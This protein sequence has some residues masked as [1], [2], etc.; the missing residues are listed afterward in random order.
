MSDLADA[1]RQAGGMLAGREP[2][3]WRIAGLSLALSVSATAGASIAA[4]PFASALAGSRF[5]GRRVVDA[6]LAAGMAFPTVLIGLILFSLFARQGPLGT[7]QLLYTP[8][9]MG[10]GQFLL[11]LPICLVLMLTALEAVDPRAREAALLL[12]ATSAQARRA[13]RR[14]ARA[15][16]FVAV[17]AAFSRVITEV[18]CALIVGGDIRGRTRVLTTAIAGDTRTGDFARALALGAILLVVALAVNLAAALLTGR[19]R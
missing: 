11:A 2:E 13:V 7:F 19:R 1:L 15:G 3:V 9:L 10:V 4:L 8:W 12:G 14:E 16:L 5:R 6:L 17:V 18:G